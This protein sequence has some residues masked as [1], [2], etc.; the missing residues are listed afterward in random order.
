MEEQVQE[1]VVEAPEVNTGGTTREGLDQSMPDVELASELP[2]VQDAVVEE[3]N[4]RLQTKEK[5][6]SKA[7]SLLDNFNSSG[8]CT[9]SISMPKHLD[10]QVGI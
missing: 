1:S 5:K 2:S 6:L 8:L 9:N 10:S 4:K 7:I 3:G